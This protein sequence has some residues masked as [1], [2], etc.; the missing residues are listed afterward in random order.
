MNK[1]ATR[2]D[3]KELLENALKNLKAAY[4]LSKI[5]S[6]FAIDGTVDQAIES[7]QLTVNRH[8]I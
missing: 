2:E 4:E 8:F 5:G 7:L 1:R 3:Q 6:E